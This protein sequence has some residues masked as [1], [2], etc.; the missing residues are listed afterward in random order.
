MDTPTLKT[1]VNLKKSRCLGPVTANSL[2][3][4]ANFNV[5]LNLDKPN[6][7]GGYF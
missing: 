2:P 7:V 5:G 4:V 3:S 1:G 6:R